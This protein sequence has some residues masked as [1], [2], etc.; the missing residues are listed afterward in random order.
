M[1]FIYI[2]IYIES[3]SG[4]CSVRT[5][6]R[7]GS[8]AEGEEMEERGGR[9]ISTQLLLKRLDDLKKSREMGEGNNTSDS[10]NMDEEREMLSGGLTDKAY[11][12]LLKIK[13]ERDYEGKP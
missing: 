13:E 4:T 1:V 5:I 3:E 12:K 9:V 7:E 11:N 10:E 6:T 8:I 2:Y